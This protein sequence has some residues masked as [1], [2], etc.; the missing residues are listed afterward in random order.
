L[1]HGEKAHEN[2]SLRTI[3][4][5]PEKAIF[6]YLPYLGQIIVLNFSSF[7][8]KLDHLLPERIIK[9]DSEGRD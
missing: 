3:A 5:S 9:E 8:V 4:K 6:E 2:T 7:A 1:A